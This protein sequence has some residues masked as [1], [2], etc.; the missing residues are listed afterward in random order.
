MT[1]NNE[2]VFNY[3]RTENLLQE[4]KG[5]SLNSIYWML[6]EKPVYEE[7]IKILRERRIYVTTIWQFGFFHQDYTAIK[8]KLLLH[9]YI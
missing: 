8:G 3:L 1:G 2:A 6:K 7:I 9:N 4:G 5:F